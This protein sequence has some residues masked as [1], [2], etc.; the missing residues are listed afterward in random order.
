[1]CWNCDESIG[2]DDP[3]ADWGEVNFCIKCGYFIMRHYETRKCGWCTKP[4]KIQVK[5]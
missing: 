1:M 2:Y 3:D 4:Q 5:G